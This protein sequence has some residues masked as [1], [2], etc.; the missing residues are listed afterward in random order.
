MGLVFSAFSWSY[1]L[2]QVPGGIFLDRFGTR[3]TY[4]VAVV[5]WS[6]FTRADG[7]C[8]RNK[9][10][11]LTAGLRPK[12][13]TLCSATN[14]RLCSAKLNP[15]VNAPFLARIGSALRRDRQETTT[16]E[17]SRP[18]KNRGRLSYQIAGRCRLWM[19][20][21]ERLASSC[22]RSHCRARSATNGLN[23][24]GAVRRFKSRCR[25]HGERHASVVRIRAIKVGEIG[26]AK[27][28]EVFG[29]DRRRSLAG[30]QCPLQPRPAMARAAGRRVRSAPLQQRGQA[31]VRTALT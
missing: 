14:S 31:H 17:R 19:P 22:K 10:L 28:D 13:T 11:L 16:A 24:F 1:A 30:P 9:S 6:L 21:S 2:L 3:V 12:Q 7:R 27:A 23:Q 4:C 15:K 20:V 5:F 18:R 29:V 8:D 25:N 26:L